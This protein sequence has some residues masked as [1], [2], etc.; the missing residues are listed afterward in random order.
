MTQKDATVGAG[1]CQVKFYMGSIRTSRSAVLGRHMV[2]RTVSE[3]VTSYLTI[4]CYQDKHANGNP[5][6]LETARRRQEEKKR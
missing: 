2:M 5:T 4:S 1:F 6:Q 3:L